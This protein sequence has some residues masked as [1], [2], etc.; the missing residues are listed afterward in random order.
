MDLEQGILQVLRVALDVP[1]LVFDGNVR[2]IRE[3]LDCL[4]EFDVF[5]RHHKREYVAA[6]AAAET[7]KNLEARIYVKARSFL[8]VERAKRLE[9]STRLFQRQACPNDIDNVIGGANSLAK[10][11]GKKT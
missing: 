6:F 10:F 11:C 9:I 7:F 4:R 2:A 1:L 5:I 3:S 8:F